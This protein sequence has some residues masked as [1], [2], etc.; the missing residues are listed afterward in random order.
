MQEWFD[1]EVESPYMLLVSNVKNNKIIE[2]TDQQKKLFGID[3]LLE[4]LD[5]MFAF[6]YYEGESDTLWLARDPAGEK[7]LY[8]SIAE[9]STYFGSELS[10]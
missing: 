8:Y 10:S 6:A 7:P 3:K 2:M 5:G 1:L 9:N 4:K